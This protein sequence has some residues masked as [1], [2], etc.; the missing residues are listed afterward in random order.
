[1]TFYGLFAMF[2]VMVVLAAVPGVSAMAVAARSAANGFVHGAAVTGGIVVADLLF[3][4]AAVFGLSTLAGANDQLFAL[5]KYLGGA[6]LVWFG[7]TL[8]RTPPG[9]GTSRDDANPSLFSGF[10]TGLFITL[11]DQKAILFYLGLFP[12][13]FDTTALSAAEMLVIAAVAVAAVGGA[14][15]A[16]ACAADRIGAL[17]R[18]RLPARAYQVAGAV[19]IATGAF[20]VANA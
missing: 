20:L 3:I 6:Y 1:M 14:K 4:L 17:A 7:I 5:V 15:L 13:F 19:V 10:L 16:Y 11:G 8:W 12:A 18:S 9:G 2:A